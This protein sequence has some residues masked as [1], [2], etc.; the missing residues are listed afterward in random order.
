MA[1]KEGNFRF[2]LYGAVVGLRKNKYL[3]PEA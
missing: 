1:E 2:R 3:K